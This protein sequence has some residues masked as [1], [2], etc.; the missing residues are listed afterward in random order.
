[1]FLAGDQAVKQPKENASYLS[2][3]TLSVHPESVLSQETITTEQVTESELHLLCY[4]L[5]ITLSK[6]QL[7]R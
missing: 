1:M 5:T 2:Q 7:D 3:N 4:R 6:P